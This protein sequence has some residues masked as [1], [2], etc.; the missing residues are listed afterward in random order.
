MDERTVARRRRFVFGS[1]IGG[2][3][4]MAVGTSVVF[5]G[6]PGIGIGLVGASLLF[7]F[8]AIVALVR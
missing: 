4:L 6:A 5:A 8:A 1:A 2:V 3:L 7:L